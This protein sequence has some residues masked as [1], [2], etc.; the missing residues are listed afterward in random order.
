LKEIISTDKN[1]SI[2]IKYSDDCDLRHP[3]RFDNYS[4]LFISEGEGVYRADFGAFPFKAP[5]ILFSTPLQ[6]IYLEDKKPSKYTLLQFHGDFYC[7]E[8][9]KEQVACNGL[10]FNNIYIQP[11]V[12]LTEP[13]AMVF[14]RLLNEIYSEFTSIT[15]DEMVL[16]SYLQ[17]FLAKASSIKIRL[18]Q[19]NREHEERDEKMEQFMQLLE[20]NF[21]KLHKPND[22][23]ELLAMSPNNF[24]KRCTR[25]FKKSPSEMIHERIILEAKKKLHLTRQSIKEIAYALNFT[26][27]FYFSRFFKKF[28]KVSPQTYREKTG[29]SI[30]ADLPV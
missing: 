8:Y 1:V 23:A 27:E 16:Q 5:V 10:L 14:E 29:I 3:Q 20:K 13:E 18:M 22:Y 30:V 12:H 7:I 26:D 19:L 24:S 9:H 21:L 15:P 6:Q 17:L 2:T 4:V 28:V 25:Y 11:S